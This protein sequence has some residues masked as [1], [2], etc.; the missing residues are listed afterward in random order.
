MRIF[1]GIIALTLLAALVMLLQ[2]LASTAAMLL[3]IAII[4]A[5]ILIA[6]TGGFWLALPLMYVT[7][8]CFWPCQFPMP[9]TNC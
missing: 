8:Y 6:L 7:F 4:G 5:V 1:G 3:G 9:W 2:G